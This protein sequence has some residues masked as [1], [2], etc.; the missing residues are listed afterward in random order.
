MNTLALALTLSVATAADR[1]NVLLLISDDHAAAHVG[2]Y[3][4]PDVKTPNL[5]RLAADGVR[6]DRF[7]AACPQCVPSRATYMTG[8]SPV[9]IG[10]TRFSAPL[11]REVVAFPELLR[12]AGYF[13]GIGGRTYHL[14]G[15]NQPPATAK[16]FEE[17]D[18]RTFDDRVDWLKPDGDRTKLPSLFKDF[19]AA[20]PEGKPFFLQLGSNDPHRS[21][22]AGPG[23]TPA[24]KLTLPPHFPDTPALRKDFSEYYAE[25]E[26]LDGDVG[27]IL[28]LLED[29]GH[30]DD[31]LVIFV[32]DNGCALL[33][34]KGTL[35]DF[36][37]RVPLIIRWPQVIAPNH[38][39][40]PGA[41]SEHVL[42][43]EDLAP[44]ILE[45]CQVQVPD[46]MTGVGFMPL[47]NRGKFN[48]RKYAFSE[49]GA[50][51]SGLPNNTAAF[52]LG[53]AVVGDRYKLIYTALPQLPYHPVDFADNDFW[54][55]IV[56]SHDAG[57]LAEP[58]ESIYFPPQRPMFQLFDLRADPHEMTNLAGRT[59]T[60]AVERELKAALQEW[61]ILE[62]DFLPL[63][64]PPGDARPNRQRP[65]GDRSR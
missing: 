2:C 55:Q 23:T 14:D 17:H 4:N 54:K 5:D 46:S 52:D 27:T 8:R 45:A 32:G 44:T 15:G 12:D 39:V 61:M 6:F 33:R 49:R 57:T 41:V 20:V 60:A 35:Y 40:E 13:T 42:S 25:I 29:S 51:G 53:R 38:P 34:G 56:A 50:H 48:P 63:P 62:R 64:I 65:R 21:F 3:G 28:R 19:L 47:L 37:I 58:F 31:T 11:P 9:A 24:E 36:G 1:P 43:G 10:M 22:N 30:A 16:V 7:Y 59:E 26:R 18:L